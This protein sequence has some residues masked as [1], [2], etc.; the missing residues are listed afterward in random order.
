MLIDVGRAARGGALGL[1]VSRRNALGAGLGLVAGLS[2]AAG[3]L[4]LGVS[5]ARAAENQSRPGFPWTDPG[6]NLKILS[7]MWGTVEEG[8]EACL[9]VFGPMF[10]MPDINTFRPL[11]RM[12][13][14]AFV[15]T[16]PAG[17]GAYRYLACQFI[18]FTDFATGEPLEKWTNPLTGETCEVF[19]YRDGP[20]DYVLDANK[21][22][23][24]Y[25]MHKEADD[26]KRRLVLDWFFRGD[27]AYG[28]AIVKT[29]LK[30]R[31]DPKEWPRES[32]GEYWETVEDYRWQAK[33]AEVENP[34]LPSIPSFT[35]DFQTFKPWEPFMLMDG[36]P[37]KIF[38]QRTAFKISNF[39]AV[40]RKVMAYAEKHLPDFLAAPT[41]FDKSYKLNDAHFK[42]QRKPQPPRAGAPK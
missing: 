29:R 5:R 15:R 28:D 33:I 20:L 3:G 10:G 41:K 37:G 12:E 36:A 18:M 30:N 4:G 2:G 42:E 9:Y 11:F 17:P 21:M 26:L 35:G 6:E 40:P 16:Y 39:D 1:S 31:L 22:A 38:S 25:E 19:H 27:M 23:E 13:S 32:V 8:K 7:R 24:R 14:L 34:N